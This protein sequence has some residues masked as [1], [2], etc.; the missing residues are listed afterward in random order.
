[1]GKFNWKKKRN[2][3]GINSLTALIDEKQKNEDLTK[4]NCELEETNRMLKV[5][6]ERMRQQPLS[7]FEHRIEELLRTAKEERAQLLSRLQK[8]DDTLKGYQEVLARAF[9]L[10]TRFEKKQELVKEILTY[11]IV[12]SG[13]V[14][15]E[16]AS[17]F[18]S[19]IFSSLLPFLE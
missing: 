14:C 6:C 18:S 12:L 8:H 19:L 5:E 2:N 10:L 16:D 17:L 9:E 13:F 3:I 11:S 4:K 15:K 7:A 1:M